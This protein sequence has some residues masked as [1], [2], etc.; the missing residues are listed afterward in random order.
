L[1]VL[2][3]F[4]AV[5]IVVLLL[6]LQQFSRGAQAAMI[7][8]WDVVADAVALQLGNARDAE[9][10]RVKAL[11]LMARY[12]IDAIEVKGPAP[13][14]FGTPS[15]AGTTLSRQSAKGLVRV[16]FDDSDLRDNARQFATTAAICVA[17]AVTG[18]IL[19]ALYIPRITRPVEKLLDHAREVGEQ[20]PQKDDTT[21]LID[22]FRDSIAR[23][24]AQEAELKQ[25]H[26]A[27][28]HR[29]DEL[30]MVSA[31]LTRSLTS[32]FLAIDPSARVLEVNAA[33]REI[34]AI[35]PESDVQMEIGA[36]VGESPLADL[37]R[38]AA[39]NGETLT[40]I[41]V[42]H[43]VGANTLTIGLT[44][45]PLI[46]EGL[47]LLGVLA[48]FTD[49]TPIKG[50]ES[51]VRAMQTLA[52]LGEITAGI[53]HEF[54]NS[55]STILGYVKLL[56]R[57][58][59][60]PE[61]VTRL[62]AAE[63]EANELTRAVQRLLT[64]AK[65]MTLEIER[66]DLRAL[67]ENA[68]D[69][70]SANARDVAFTL[71][72]NA[73]IDGDRTLLGRAIENVIRNAV[74]AVSERGADAKVDVELRDDPPAIVVRDNGAGFDEADAARL[75]LP[76]VSNKPGGFGLGLSLTRKI[77]VL[78]GGEIQMNGTPGRG[79]VITMQFAP[80]RA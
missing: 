9:D 64:F 72:G 57:S 8:R 3:G 36:L 23:L 15:N 75:L 53:A 60:P 47:R 44:A 28:K 58:D 1:T 4:L 30:E 51:R 56:L 12:D 38:R 33:G 50:L 73:T 70:A 32:G 34:L 79:A 27:E 55:L 54:R 19:L 80:K 39:R 43:T 22:T 68:I 62:R 24:K 35:S 66:V 71:T 61:A 42:E 77:M 76:F 29:A 17:A 46:G 5:L 20:E 14:T 41:E 49:L 78:H 26:E 25:L 74:E 59:L 37:L 48:L 45:V 21:Y 10:M 2:V 7:R 31:T 52:E 63:Q 65:P 40:R 67:A 6:L 16:T 69:H 13:Q 18:L 11:L